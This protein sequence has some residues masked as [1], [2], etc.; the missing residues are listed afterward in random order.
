MQTN[1]LEVALEDEHA[2][3]L[4][5]KQLVQEREKAI[6]QLKDESGFLDKQYKYTKKEVGVFRQLVGVV[7]NSIGGS[8]P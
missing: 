6:Q 1:H 4:E 5:L 2:Q 7:C 3:H 8:C